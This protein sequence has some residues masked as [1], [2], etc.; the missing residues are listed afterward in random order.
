MENIR[1]IQIS[2]TAFVKR[3]SFAHERIIF[4]SQLLI[5]FLLWDEQERYNCRVRSRSK[6]NL[7]FYDSLF[8]ILTLHLRTLNRNFPSCPKQLHHNI[9]RSACDDWYPQDWTSL[10]V[11]VQSY[12]IFNEFLSVIFHFHLPHPT[13]SN[14]IFVG[15]NMSFLPSSKSISLVFFRRIHIKINIFLA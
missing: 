9:Y 6:F 2:P 8:N 13:H 5:Y 3:T 1:F 14:L 4:W 7:T 15:S 10:A 11:L 12:L